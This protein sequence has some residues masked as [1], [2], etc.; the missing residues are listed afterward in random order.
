LK[1]SR[2]QSF[3]RPALALELAGLRA[4]LT[5]ADETL[6]AIRTGEV[7]TVVVAGKL[8]SRVFTLDGAEHAYRVLIESM[9]EGAL[10]ITDD[11]TILYANQC[12]ARMV[13]CPLEQV[14]GGS[15]RRFLS[16][17]DRA[18]LRTLLK[19]GG[20]SG[21]KVQVLLRASDGGRLPAH[22]SI[23]RLGR[24]GTRNATFGIVVTDMTESRYNEERL[25]T[26]TRRV[27]QAQEGERRRVALELHDNITQLICAILFRS[28]ALADRL[29]ARD[30][31]SKRE[32]MKICEMLGK[33]AREV[34]RISRN[35]RPGVLAQLGLVAVLR[36]TS[37]EF[38][39][40]TGVPV[41]LV[42]AQ[43][44]GRLP[45]DTELTLLRI[46]QE[47][48]KNVE[49]HAGAH[50]VSVCLTQQGAYVLLAIQD[51]GIGFDP[52]LHWPGRKGKAGLGLLGMRE[53]ATYVG[54]ALKVKSVPHAGTEI[55]VRI[56][57]AAA[58]RAAG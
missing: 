46:L 16:A 56:P 7:D 40:R 24:S 42:C 31:S 13:R 26:L 22:L 1:P 11:K 57:M 23:R 43:L 19:K 44:A 49:K 18:A 2:E 5:E 15:L 38:A 33:T 36:G 45:A 32:A 21:S 47:A 6:R 20:M 48:L 35:L 41:E 17:E 39:D 10:T 55:E 37:S 58:A 53:R 8:G 34:E 30:G 27:V 4:R 28:Q 14:M 12:F 52:D 51:D 3:S 9:N 25:R 54:G 50:N 29:P